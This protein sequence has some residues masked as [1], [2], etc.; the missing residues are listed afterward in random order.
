MQN[1]DADE[2]L[3]SNNKKEVINLQTRFF[4]RS[5]TILREPSVDSSLYIMS[6]INF[7]NSIIE[8]DIPVTVTKRPLINSFTM[9]KIEPIIK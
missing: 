9:V 3:A 5:C 4:L 2:S 7:R 6:R 1:F 8:T